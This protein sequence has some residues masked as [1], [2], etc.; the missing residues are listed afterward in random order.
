MAFCLFKLDT[1][2]ACCLFEAGWRQALFVLQFESFLAF[3]I[4]SVSFT[5]LYQFFLYPSKPKPCKPFFFLS[6]SLSTH[7]KSILYCFRCTFLK[8]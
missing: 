5:V 7:L 4:F 2:K 1:G 6:F 8:K 3:V